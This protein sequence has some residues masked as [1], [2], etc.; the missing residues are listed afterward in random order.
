MIVCV[1]IDPLESLDHEKDSSLYLIREALKRGYEVW[2]YQP[3]NL[4]IENSIVKAL[5]K[6]SVTSYNSIL[7]LNEV[8][9]IL[10]RNNPP[11]DLAYISSL[12]LLQNISSS[13]LILNDPKALLTISEKIFISQYPQFTPPTIITQSLSVAQKFLEEHEDVI[14]KPLYDFGGNGITRIQNKKALNKVLKKLFKIYKTPLII[15]K[16]LKG[17]TLGDKRVSIINGEIKNPFYRVPKKDEFR[18]NTIWGST[19][20]KCTLTIREEKA[21]KFI[22]KILSKQGIIFAGLDIIDGYVTE[23]NV[24]SVGGIHFANTLYNLQ[25]SDRIESLIWNAIEKLKKQY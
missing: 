12:H 13:T 3:S 6:H 14:I 22:G 16:F 23:V 1:Q 18:A 19:I 11:I 21:C 25:G 4:Y 5:A 9:V 7:N 10:I 15:Q 17:V 24:T 8:D 2:T 20:E